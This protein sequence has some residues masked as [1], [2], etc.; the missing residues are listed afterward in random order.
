MS[1]QHS[2]APPTGGRFRL[3]PRLAVLA[4]SI[5]LVLGFVE[6]LLHMRPQ[7]LPAAYRS[8]YPLYGMEFFRPGILSET[9]LD[10]VPLPLTQPGFEGPPPTDLVR[11]GIA[12]ASASID[13][14]RYPTFRIPVDGLGF[15]NERV[16]DRAD[17]VFIGDSFCLWASSQEPRGLI[18]RVQE[19]TG[20]SAYSTGIAGLG[21]FQEAWLVEHVALP[22]RPR[23]VVWFFF[24][25]NDM[26]TAD[27]ITRAH[28]E[29]KT[30]Y[31]ERED[32][33]PTPR[34]ILPDLVEYAL[35]RQGTPSSAPLDPFLLP[36][37]S[38]EDV[39]VWFHPRYLVELGR[40]RKNLETSGGW[41]P[42][43]QTIQSCR[44]ATV[45]QGAS[46]LMVYIPSKAQVYLP[47]VR[48][49]PPLLL[50]TL[51]SLS[52]EL[53]TTPEAA[54]D[55]ILAH[56]QDLEEAFGSFC[57]AEQ[58]PFLSATPYL[59]E[60]AKRG[61]TGYFT[62]DTHWSP[63]GQRAFFGPLLAFLRSEGLDR[64]TPTHPARH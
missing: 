64:N 27:Y 15:P 12:P 33:H 58:I 23:V 11:M 45:A 59:E 63:A 26:R 1:S 41:K 28:A 16:L 25:G 32:Y 62:T 20:C 34:W 6:L 3:L 51:R 30:M 48:S 22:L 56:R 13:V 54:Q 57:R 40:S 14:Q 19:E 2:H 38:F 35:R 10:S 31:T 8:S 18:P 17:I 55:F 49:N 37:P 43:L 5:L 4:A 42:L 52:P 21:P 60:L 50:R 46:F 53:A 39:P 61:E 36:H 7:L 9:L 24:A 47:H 44:D 29:G